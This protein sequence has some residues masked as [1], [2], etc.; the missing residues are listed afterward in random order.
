MPPK[1]PAKK[2]A[3]TKEAKPATVKCRKQLN[4]PKKGAG[5]QA[6]VNVEKVVGSALQGKMD[7][8]YPE[9]SKIV[10]IFTSSTFTGKLHVNMIYKFY[11]IAL[12]LLWV[13]NVC[14]DRYN[15]S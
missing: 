10:R 9:T 11:N 8:D 3:A 6:T 7:C 14:T 4:I 15:V 5:A 13:P 1:A 12:K 2:P